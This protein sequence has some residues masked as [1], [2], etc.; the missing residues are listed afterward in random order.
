M[1]RRFIGLLCFAVLGSA[2]ALGADRRDVRRD[3]RHDR[4]DRRADRRDIRSDR[5][6]IRHD[7][8][9]L[10]RDLRTGIIGLRD[11]SVGIFA[12]IGATSGAI[13][14]ICAPT[15][16]TS[17]ATAEIFERAT[18]KEEDRLNFE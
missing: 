11:V 18:G 5:R 10:R 15:V 17:A 13:I 4:I 12:P 16:A 3:L 8:H 6:D 1:R 9:Q 7:R 14:A 2:F